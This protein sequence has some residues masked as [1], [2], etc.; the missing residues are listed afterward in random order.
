MVTMR[1]F[2]LIFAVSVSLVLLS[3]CK[4]VAP[5]STD[6][7]F[8]DIYILGSYSAS[9]PLENEA[10]T[11]QTIAEVSFDDGSAFSLAMDLPFLMEQ[12]TPY[13]IDFTLS[14]L[15]ESFGQLSDVAR[16]TIEPTGGSPYEVV[17]N[18]SANFID[19]DIDNDG[20][21]DVAFGGQ[22][23]DDSDPE[24]FGGLVPH[25]EVCDGKDNDCD[26]GLGPDEGDLDGDGIICFADCDDQDADVYGGDSPHE[27]ICDNKD[28]DCDGSL[29]E[30]ELDGDGDGVSACAGDCEPRTAAAH[31][32]LVEVCDGFDTDCD[33]ATTVFGGELDSDGDGYIP[34]GPYQE[35]GAGVFGGGDC[36][37][38]RPTVYGGTNPAPELC[39]GLDNDCD[40]YLLYDEVDEDGDS[41]LACVDCNDDSNAA[42]PGAPELCN[43]LDD[44]CDGIANADVGLEID[45]D[46]DGI[47]SCDDCDDQDLNSYPGAA[48]L[49]DGLDN[50][51]NGF[52]DLGGN[53]AAE[54]DLD[55]DGSP[56]CADCDDG[57]PARFPGNPEQCDGGVDNDCDA[58]TDES[59]D[60]DG[61]GHSP[62]GSDGVAGGG[63]DDCDELNP[64]TY[65]GAPELCDGNDN[66]CNGQADF[67]GLAANEA[68]GDGD[69]SPFCAD[70]DDG[71]AL[72]FPNNPEICDGADNDCDSATFADA[73]GEADGDSDGSLSCAD[74]DDA[75]SERFPGNLEICDGLDNDCDG[76]VPVTEADGDADGSIA[77]ADCDDGDALNFPGNVEIC[78]NQDNDCDVSSN[79]DI[80]GDG[81]GISTCDG[82]CHDDNVAV[83]PGAPQELCDG[84]DN[85]C[86][87]DFFLG[88][89]ADSDGDGSI[90]CLDS[91]CPHYVD[92]DFVGTSLGTSTFPWLTID[93]AISAATGAGCNAVNVRAGN[94]VGPVSWPT[95]VDLRVVGVDGAA[96]TIL[97]APTPANPGEGSGPIV[98]ID[99]GQS[100]VALLHGFT[101][102]GASTVGTTSTSADGNGGAIRV[103]GASPTLRSLVVQGNQATGSG[104]GI[105]ASNSSLLIDDCVFSGNL[106]EQLSGG[107][108]GVYTSGGAPVIRRSFFAG[109]SAADN[110]GGLLLE[111]PDGPVELA[112]NT[113]QGNH[114]HDGAAAYLNTVSGQVVQNLFE[115][116]GAL[117]SVNS[118]GPTD[119][120]GAVYL[121]SSNS[122]SFFNNIFNAN[123]GS[124]ASAMFVYNSAPLLEHN[125]FV[126]NISPVGAAVGAALRTFGGV[127]RHNIFASNTG[128]GIEIGSAVQAPY[129]SSGAAEVQYNLFHCNTVG[130]SCSST[131]DFSSLTT[132]FFGFLD[133]G[134][135][136]RPHEAGYN[137]VANGYAHD[138]DGDGIP[139]FF[140]PQADGNINSTWAATG[141]EPGFVAFSA[142]QDPLNDD[143]SLAPG[144]ICIDAGDPLVFDLDGSRADIGAFG[145]L[146]GDWL[147]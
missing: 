78:D 52:A 137:V 76:T 83:F 135:G 140:D 7:N 71:N 41:F 80:D 38:A 24:I 58:A 70:C 5:A 65:P 62:C 91:D 10:A 114:A 111:N 139:D 20:V 115:A 102:T 119:F 25:E 44:D 64:Q 120:G 23:C 106:A 97:S 28:N 100:R 95:G 94:Y 55:A 143:L 122:A 133:D 131:I 121:A 43:G 13:A 73:E 75:D 66:D 67:A 36:D 51:C 108:G 2:R 14:P 19:G 117:D 79:E 134:V 132:N 127:Y 35:A 109:N 89:D 77:C 54:F 53:S 147:P 113:F 30:D 84:L 61:D 34:C 1:T 15:P 37:D 87:G 17:V 45:G 4:G 141:A 93:Q 69:G 110:G 11:A 68:D 129:G 16:F 138:G 103:S 39:D 81:D 144:S 82:D 128:A 105:A 88:E 47:R 21:V 26:G 33:P 90:D 96:Q 12:R 104:G 99:G 125:V 74:C 146:F 72:V 116:N 136:N 112:G 142:D 42:F 124:S 27:E 32:G 86:D 145:G 50:D 101:L 126:D 63:D 118:I 130:T 85:D 60:T 48:E 46:G 57:D 3:G 29:G 49:C 22:D 18:L 6:L 123:T 107:G 8:G 56:A 9:T 31:P 98:T 59:Q 40:G 92:D